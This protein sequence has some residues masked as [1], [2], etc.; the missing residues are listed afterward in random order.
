MNNLTIVGR[1]GRDPELRFTQDGKAV[2]NFSVATDHGRDDNKKTTW[3]NIVAFGT[4]AEN[5]VRSFTKGTR[6]I[7][8]GRLD[9]SEYETKD[10]EKKKKTELIADAL[11]VEI[12]FDPATVLKGHDRSEEDF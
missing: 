10:G 9:V 6:V 7:C 2:A 1:I 11:G 12:R 5:A 8:S 3:H 4:M